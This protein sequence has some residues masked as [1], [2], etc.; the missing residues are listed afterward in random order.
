MIKARFE[1]S[2][3]QK[4]SEYCRSILLGKVTTVKY[5]NESLDEMFEELVTLRKELN[6]V[7]NNLNQAVHKLNTLDVVTDHKLL[8]VLKD[9]IFE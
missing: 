8:T 5:R 9:V 2:T 1:K 6:A 7:G 3:C 4:M